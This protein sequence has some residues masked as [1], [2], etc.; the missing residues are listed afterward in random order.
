V[1]TLTRFR[2]TFT[3]YFHAPVVAPIADCLEHLTSSFSSGDISVSAGY[4]QDPMHGGRF[5]L[6]ASTPHSTPHSILMFARRSQLAPRN[7]YLVVCAASCQKLFHFCSQN[8]K[9][10]FPYPALAVM[11][12]PSEDSP[13]VLTSHL[14]SSKWYC[15]R[16]PIPLK[17]PRTSPTFAD[18][19]CAQLES[20]TPWT[21][22][23]FITGHYSRLDKDVSSS[24]D[25]GKNPL[26]K[27]FVPVQCR[28]VLVFVVENHFW[29]SCSQP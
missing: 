22:D 13:E 18:A 9:L 24:E 23:H 5:C 20:D 1:C 16:A 21:S 3:L 11:A 14:K 6:K 17:S 8:F 4:F 27:L 15:R 12:N 25:G 29:I 10:F 19:S 2:A 7:T 26:E 28:F